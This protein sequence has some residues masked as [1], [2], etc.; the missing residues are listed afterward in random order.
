MQVYDEEC[1]HGLTLNTCVIC[2]APKKVPPTPNLVRIAKKNRKTPENSSS[3]FNHPWPLWFQMRD[4]G[5]VHIISRARR[6]R[7]T[8]YGELW[9]AIEAQIGEGLGNSWRQLP[10][11]LGDIAEH[12][13]DEIGLILTALVIY[14]EGDEHPGEGFF[15]LAAETGMPREEDAPPVGEPW[16]GMTSAQRDFWEIQVESLFAQFGET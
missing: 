2:K 10:H 11:L 8:C 4:A 12:A 6:Q 14:E 7:K 16:A 3:Y 5:A 13:F 9:T 1:I 15:R